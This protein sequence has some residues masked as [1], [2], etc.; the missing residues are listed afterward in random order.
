M[1]GTR[2]I[3]AAGADLSVPAAA[4]KDEGATHSDD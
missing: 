1:A 4:T 3:P 2:G